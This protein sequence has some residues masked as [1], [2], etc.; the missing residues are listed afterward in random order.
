MQ[1]IAPD[2]GWNRPELHAAHATFSAARGCAFVRY[3]PAAHATHDV[4]ALELW[5]V[6]ASQR[7]HAAASLD[8]AGA[9]LRY[10]PAPQATHDICPV[11]SW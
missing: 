9:P 5:N 2:T 8:D 6:P 3:L 1:A 4:L 7:V 11:A 10:F